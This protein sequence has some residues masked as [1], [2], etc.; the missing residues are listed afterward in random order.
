[1]A[2]AKKILAAETKAVEAKI[3]PPNFQTIKILIEG[4]AP[5][6][7]ERF[8]V[9]A[10][11]MAKMAEGSTA[12]SKKTRTAR[13]FD[14]DA[15]RAKHISEEGWE[16]FAASALRAAGISANIKSWSEKAKLFAPDVL[17]WLAA[18]PSNDIEKVAVVTA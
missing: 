14:A 16:G 12:R 13:D 18:A 5:L 3:T 11:M 10:E 1:M 6:V 8:A 7:Q 15:Q 2:T 9:K 4:T 17:T